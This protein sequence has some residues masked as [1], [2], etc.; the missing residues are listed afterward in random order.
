MSIKEN[1]EYRKCDISYSVY[2]DDQSWG[3]TFHI[4]IHHNN[5]VD[6]YQS[7]LPEPQR[8][9]K[10]AME[11]MKREAR[12]IIDKWIIKGKGKPIQ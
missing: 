6:D 3:G 7:T 1:E 4:I 11:K 10:S 5:G 8:S 12:E 9:S 2:G